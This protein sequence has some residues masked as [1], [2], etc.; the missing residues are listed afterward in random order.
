M[1]CV[2][3][4]CFEAML[5]LVDRSEEVYFV[6]IKYK[7]FCNSNNFFIIFVDKILLQ[8][9]IGVYTTS[10]HNCFMICRCN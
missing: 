7:F 3:K 8:I 5:V 6:K 2:Q 4:Y 10:N 9:A 1:H